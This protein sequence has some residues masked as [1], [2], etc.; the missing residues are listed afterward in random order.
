MC[1][2]GRVYIVGA[3]ERTLGVNWLYSK[4]REIERAR[5]RGIERERE[6]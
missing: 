2:S 5:E 1:E 3:Y 6:G 4:R